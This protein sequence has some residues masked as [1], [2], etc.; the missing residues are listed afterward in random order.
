MPDAANTD[1][2]LVGFMAING[3]KQVGDQSG[4]DLYHQPIPASGNQ[5]VHL[6][7]AFPPCEKL[8][9]FPTEL[10]HFGD[11]FGGQIPAIGSNPIIDTFNAISYKTNGRLCSGVVLIGAQK[12][13]AS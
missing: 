8:F 7:V 6:Q 9:N 11:L 13:S 2:L 5:V 12:T 4:V 3:Q 10:I 1:A